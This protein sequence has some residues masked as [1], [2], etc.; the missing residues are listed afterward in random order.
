MST[1]L[2]VTVTESAT[3]IQYICDGE[4]IL[5]HT[6]PFGLQHAEA[7]GLN[8]I[9]ASSIRDGVLFALEHISL[10]DRIPTEIRL[11]APMHAPW[12]QSVLVGY[13]YAQFYMG[14][15]PMRV[16]LLDKKELFA[17]HQEQVDSSS[18]S[19]HPYARH[20]KTVLSFKI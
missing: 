20:S 2:G 7:Y 16:T 4:V 8:K 10:Y 3:H 11:L 9:A 14:G 17:H 15:V 18:L 12:L 1:H 19:S 5:S 13:D 6:H